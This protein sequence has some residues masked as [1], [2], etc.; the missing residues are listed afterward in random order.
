M[1]EWV[2]QLEYGIP[3]EMLS[4]NKMQ[5]R[6]VYEKSGKSEDSQSS[7]EVGPFCWVLIELANAI[8]LIL[9]DISR[10]RIVVTHVHNNIT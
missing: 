8:C 2:S 3:G 5:W 1:V 10:N 7:L 6:H 4:Q 9:S